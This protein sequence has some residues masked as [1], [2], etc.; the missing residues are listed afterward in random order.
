MQFIYYQNIEM[1][2]KIIFWQLFVYIGKI[3]NIK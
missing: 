3:K 1:S 2:L